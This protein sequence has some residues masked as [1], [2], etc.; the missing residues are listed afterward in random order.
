MRV[1]LD[2]PSL[3]V[4]RDG[5]AA[6]RYPVQ[7]LSRVIVCGQAR[8]DCSVLRCCA[9]NGV[10]VASL[11]ADGE[12][13]VFHLPWKRDRE[14]PGELLEEF[15]ERVDW[16][17]RWDCWRSAQE[18]REVL[19]TLRAMGLPD[20][21]AHPIAAR[22]ALSRAA[23]DRPSTWKLLESWR[24][25]M[26]LDVQAALIEAGF[27]ADLVS[28]RRH[29]LSLG[30]VF[31]DVLAWRHWND[32]ARG[33]WTAKRWREAVAGYESMRRREETRAR[34]LADRFGYWL[35]GTRWS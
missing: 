11:S 32:V 24:G 5:D 30:A 10:P 3:L 28:G 23:G 8:M 7:R 15:L 14:R 21:A 6:R 18:R 25:L 1:K 2:G 33:G 22:S 19:A 12:P 27:A 16:R 4:E 20:H 29:G 26:A 17:G 34:R 31:C 35:G 13:S 9:E